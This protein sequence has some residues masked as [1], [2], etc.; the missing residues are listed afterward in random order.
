MVKE[1]EAMAFPKAKCERIGATDLTFKT[2]GKEGEEMFLQSATYTG[3]EVRLYSEQAVF[4][5]CPSHCVL[6]TG[7]SN[8]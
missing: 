3:Y 7:I 4:L 1:G 6:F 8:A 5:P 2:P